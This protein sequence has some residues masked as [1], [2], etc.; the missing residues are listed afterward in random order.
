LSFAQLKKLKQPTQVT[1]VGWVLANQHVRIQHT[2]FEHLSGF[3]VILAKL[4]PITR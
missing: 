2:A 4:Q 3:Q 1:S